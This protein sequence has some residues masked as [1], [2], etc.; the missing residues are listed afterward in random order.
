MLPAISAIITDDEDFG[1][2]NLKLLFSRMFKD[3][4]VLAEASSVHQLQLL[5]EEHRPDVVFLDIRMPGMSGIEF[6][7]RF[8]NR[9][10]E[11]ILVTAYQDYGIRALKAGALDYIMKPLD[12]D[13]L[14]QALAKVKEQRQSKGSASLQE[15]KGAPIRIPHSRGISLIAPEDIIRITAHNNY[16][17]LSF[18]DAPDLTIAKTIKEMEARLEPLGFFR[19]HKSHLI[20]LQHLHSYS[21]EDGGQVVMTDK[22][23][24]SVSKRRLNPF[25]ARLDAFSMPLR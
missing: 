25:L 18:V 12:I 9:E 7:E 19:I 20:N 5:L 15:G 6:L 4:E 14:R 24:L 23:R 22:C 11:V 16:V 2:N 21:R 8:P 1:R 10:F 3:V 17:T 13:E